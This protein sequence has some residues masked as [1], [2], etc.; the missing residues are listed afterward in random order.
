MM[1]MK[2]INEIDAIEIIETMNNVIKMNEIFYLNL[3]KCDYQFHFIF[4]MLSFH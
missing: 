3:I 2:I 4:I 1:T